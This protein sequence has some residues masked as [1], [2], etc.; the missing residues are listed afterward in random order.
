MK[1][2]KTPGVGDVVEVTVPHGRLRAGTRYI[3]TDVSPALTPDDDEYDDP[4][5]YQGALIHG[6]VD[7]DVEAE[8]E[9]VKVVTPASEVVRPSR[10]DV[11]RAIEVDSRDHTWFPHLIEPEGEE[12]LITFTDQ[13]TGQ[14]WVA[15]IV[16]ADVWRAD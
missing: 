11:A 8:V 7:G 1:H 16:V 5:I 14:D 12:T 2:H 4:S 15:R 9:K 6:W 3:V 10:K 13:A